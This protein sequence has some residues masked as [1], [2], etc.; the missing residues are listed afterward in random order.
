MKYLIL[1]LF[2][3][4]TYLQA[5]FGAEAETT[6]AYKILEGTIARSIIIDDLNQI[7][8]GGVDF[9]E[10]E[11]LAVERSK[12]AA[13]VKGKSEHAA[14]EYEKV[15]YMD[16]YNQKSS[17]VTKNLKR[18]SALYTSL[19]VLSPE[20]CGV[21]AQLEGNKNTKKTTE[22]VNE[23]MTHQ[24]SREIKD[25]IEKLKEQER[26]VKT[27]KAINSYPTRLFNKIL[28]KGIK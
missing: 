22:A 16:Q 13:R 24:K 3:Y 11:A 19:C 5:F 17:Q 9:S 6:K 23:M 12:T 10:L 14:A 26:K 27:I 20:S 1:L 2:T 18:V 25:E 28:K 4:P 8:E 7:R 21:A 15:R